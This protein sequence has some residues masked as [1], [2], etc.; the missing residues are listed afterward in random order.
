MVRGNT[1]STCKIIGFSFPSWMKA[2]FAN[3]I[4][5]LFIV[6]LDLMLVAVIVICYMELE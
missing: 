5:S 6:Y 2:H 1:L 4:S 3:L